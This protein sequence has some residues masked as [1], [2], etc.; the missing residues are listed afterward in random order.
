MPANLPKINSVREIGKPRMLIEYLRSIS[1]QTDVPPKNIER[2]RRINEIRDSD[3]VSES[4]VTCRMEKVLIE[5]MS[6]NRNAATK[7]PRKTLSRKMPVMVTDAIKNIVM[8]LQDQEKAVINRGLRLMPQPSMAICFSLISYIAVSLLQGVGLPLDAA[9]A[10][11][12]G[13]A[14]SELSV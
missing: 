6:R 12:E 4:A 7:I 14:G 9:V 1:F 13:I 8:V 5:G 3:R 2:R 11:V 10:V